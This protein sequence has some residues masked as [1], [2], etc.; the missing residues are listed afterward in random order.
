MKTLLEIVN[1]VLPVFLV[2]G[3]GWALAARGFI[4]E[5]DNAWLSRLV[6]WVST[7]VLLFHSASK[8]PLSQALSP[9][10]LGVA[11]VV[12]GLFAGLVYLFGFRAAPARRGVLAQGSFRTNMVFVGLP[13]IANAF[14]DKPEVMGPMAVLIGFMTPLYNVI[15]VIA[16]TLPHRGQ[17]EARG[18]WKKPAR[19]IASN[20]LL[21]S[22]AIGILFSGLH[23]SLPLVLDRSLDLV[24][25]T[26]TPLALLSVGAA[27]DLKK[28]R[29]DLGPAALIAAFKLILY[30]AAV[31]LALYFLGLRGLPLKVPVLLFAAPTAVVSSIMARE[32]KGDD[33]L[34]SSLV[35]GSTLAS[36]LTISAWVACF[37]WIP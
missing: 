35:V 15:S 32:M 26:A 11:F 27:L 9:A 17:S 12:T 24:G 8:T 20:P 18:A 19:D 1:V 13:V 31:F 6:F 5:G 28:L 22:C 30:P 23:F 3:T 21:L 4:T 29:A 10:A 34:A 7:P 36:L 33:R 16:L 14:G 37:Q 2:I 25:K